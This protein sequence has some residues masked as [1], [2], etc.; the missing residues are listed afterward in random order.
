MKHVYNSL[1]TSQPVKI[2]RFSAGK[3][4]VDDALNQE[5]RVSCSK[6]RSNCH[7]LEG[8]HAHA[9]SA[10][11]VYV[12]DHPRL[13][14]DKRHET[15]GE[16][17]LITTR[18]RKIVLHRLATDVIVWPIQ[19]IALGYLHVCKRYRYRNV[20]KRRTH[21][22]LRQIVHCYLVVLNCNLWEPQMQQGRS[23]SNDACVY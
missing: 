12:V 16:Q 11:L 23:D 9:R 22:T 18:I 7:F 1:L 21:A 20:P 14:K 5:A 19:V 2:L 4:F 17:K 15:T 10:E 6:R 8:V 13:I 3:V